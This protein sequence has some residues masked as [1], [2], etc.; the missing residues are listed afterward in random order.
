[1]TQKRSPAGFAFRRERVWLWSWPQ[2][3]QGIVMSVVVFPCG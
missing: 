2:L 1:M 3:A